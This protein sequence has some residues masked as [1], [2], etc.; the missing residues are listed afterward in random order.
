MPESHNVPM[1]SA[2]YYRWVSAGRPLT[3]ARPVRDVVDRMKLAYPKAAAKNLFSWYANEAHYQAVP[4]QDHTPFSATGWPGKSPEWWVFATDIMH[5]PD[6][7]VDCT[8]LFPYWLGEAKA[9]RFPSLKYIIWQAKLYSIQNNWSP[10]SNSGHFDHIHLSF[11]TDYQNV[12]LGSWSLIPGGSNDDD[13][14]FFQVEDQGAGRM[15]GCTYEFAPDFPTLQKWQAAWPG[16]PT[17]KIRRADLL[18]G[19]YGVS[20][21]RLI[22]SSGPAPVPGDGLTEPEVRVIVRDELDHTKLVVD[23]E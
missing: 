23:Q 1:A 7:G 2:A 8:V 21:D 17:K 9:G 12:S 10:Q 18:A 5:R 13:M 14:F 22:N 20:M 4:P 6:L 15:N 11:R 3:P 16:V 19:V